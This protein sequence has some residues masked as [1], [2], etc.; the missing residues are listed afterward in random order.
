MGSTD[1][2]TAS[3]I[4]SVN[5]DF[6]SSRSTHEDP[7]LPTTEQKGKINQIRKSLR[8][9]NRLHRFPALPDDLK[10]VSSLQGLSNGGGPVLSLVRWF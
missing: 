1:S 9:P 6:N 8:L 4:S 10:G 7:I 3:T 2:S 5:D